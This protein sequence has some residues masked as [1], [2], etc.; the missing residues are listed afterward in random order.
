MEDI[1]IRKKNEVYLKVDAEP[2]LNYELA[3]FFTF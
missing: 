2:G 1:L 3:D